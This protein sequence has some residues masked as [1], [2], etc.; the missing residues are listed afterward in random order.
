MTS[1]QQSTIRCTLEKKI[2]GINNIVFEKSK[3]HWKVYFVVGSIKRFLVAS[4]TPSDHRSM[5]EVVLNA[6]RALRGKHM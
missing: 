2:L 1:K 4:D 6:K 5:Q 3:K